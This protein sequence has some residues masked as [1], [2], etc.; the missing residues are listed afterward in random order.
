MRTTKR[1][2]WLILIGVLAV[3]GLFV[4]LFSLS[5]TVQT[6]ALSVLEWFEAQGASGMLL[7][8]AMY[9]VIV[10]LLVPA[11]IF[12]IGAGFVFGFWQGFLVVIVSMAISAPIAFFVARYAFGERVAHRLKEHPKLRLLN[13]GLESEGWKIVLLSRL[14]P[15]F[16]FKLS[17]YFFGVTGVP[18]RGF[19]VGT[20]VGLL[21][22][23]VVNV[24]IGSIA[25]RLTELVDRDPTPLEWLLYGV[26][27]TGGILLV[28]YIARL[29]NG[30]MQ[31][32]IAT[33]KT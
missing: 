21:P 19:Y 11:I 12:T 16:P 9:V 25:S 24:Y 26:G 15:G 8:I 2:E 1:M 10:L 22:L 3:A 29:A 5:E 31:R 17:N 27:L 13:K 32:A 14:V 30:R 33:D 4:A 6:A 28:W 18:F 20:I 7:Y 23:T